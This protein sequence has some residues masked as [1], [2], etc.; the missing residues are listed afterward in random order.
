MR[1]LSTEKENKVGKIK[2]SSEVSVVLDTR[3]G[4]GDVR[5]IEPHHRIVL[6]VPP[7]AP[8]VHRSKAREDKLCRRGEG[9]SS[10]ELSAADLP[11]RI[12]TGLM[13]ETPCQ[14]RFS[15]PMTVL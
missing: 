1:Q 13:K 5:W 10:V 9:L 12:P 11:D 8:V 3:I 2:R 4:L 14:S 7:T 15:I 6:S